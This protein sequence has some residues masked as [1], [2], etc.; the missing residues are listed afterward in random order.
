MREP[1]AFAAGSL[2]TVDKLRAAQGAAP[3]AEGQKKPAAARQ[4]FFRE[5]YSSDR[6]TTLVAR[7]PLA[8]RG[9]GSVSKETF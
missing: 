5:D 6:A 2:I 1:A 8:P 7:T 4:A 3:S 9:S